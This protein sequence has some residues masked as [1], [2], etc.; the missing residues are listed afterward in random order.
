M[1]TQRQT[2]DTHTDTKAMQKYTSTQTWTHKD[3]PHHRPTIKHRQSAQA[4]KDADTHKH[5]HK[6]HLYG[7]KHT[8][9]I[10]E[11]THRYTRHT[12]TYT[13]RGSTECKKEN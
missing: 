10:S 13:H 2:P 1:H 5:T 11:Y 4:Q 7:F 8:G 12:Y 3:I 9:H 6:P